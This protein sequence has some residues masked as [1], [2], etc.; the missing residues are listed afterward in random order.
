MRLSLSFHIIVKAE[1]DDVDLSRY[2][3]MLKLANVIL[4]LANVIYQIQ[5]YIS[6]SKIFDLIVTKASNLFIKLLEAARKF[7]IK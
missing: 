3:L 2:I 7:S 1:V 4:Q 6:T 5:I